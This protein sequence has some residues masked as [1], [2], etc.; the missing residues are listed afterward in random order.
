MKKVL[1]TIMTTVMTTVLLAGCGSA[2]AQETGKETSVETT[3]TVQ[4][5]DV[6]E[7]AQGEASGNVTIWYYWE[8]ISHQKA[9]NHLIEEYNNSQD[10]VTV[11][12]K[13]VP[14]AD[15]KKQLSIGASADVLPDIVLLDN[16]DHASYAAMG[17]FADITDKFDVST[18]YDG[19]VN[20]CTLDERLYGVP[21]GSNCLLLY[22]NED[23][24]SAA[25][26]EVPTT[27]DE[28][29]DTAKACS[30]DNVSGFA[31]CSLQNEE[32]T[33]NFLTWVWS[34]GA[35]S[36]EIN[37]PQGIKALTAV[38]KMVEEGA[39]T[40]E[41]INWTQGDTMNQFISGNL[42][43]MINGTWQV[44]TMRTEVPDL[45]W[46]VA[47][48]PMDV[49]QASGLGGE[50]YAVIAGGNEA[51]A[52]DFLKFATEE[53]NC[54]YMMNAMGY[55]SSDSKIAEKQ[56]KGDEVYEAFVEEMNYAH[57][58]GPMPEWPDVSDA[59]SLAFNEVMTGASTPEDAAAK[60]QAT[61]DGILTQ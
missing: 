39:M 55:I 60:A 3:E 59:I 37:S 26:R 50:N 8:N 15:F 57:A 38:Q 24:L 21:F 42:A 40:K 32:G 23:M 45:N 14:F 22:Y 61:I 20:S 46:G 36:Y 9:L 31:H 25:N 11:E 44:E 5:Q 7:Q 51:A 12:A 2:P 17:I 43:M 13:Y 49:Q 53:E 34:T 16:P 47:P 48:I 52:V 41:A 29:L 54:L 28:L 35:T 30:K 4:E 27:W 19:P 1:A 18:Y 6:Q 33:F 58:R 10:A 56:F